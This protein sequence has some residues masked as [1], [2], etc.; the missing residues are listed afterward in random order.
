MAQFT[1]NPQQQTPIILPSADTQKLLQTENGYGNMKVVSA[2][3]VTDKSKAT[4][5]KIFM[6][7]RFDK[8][9]YTDE[10]GSEVNLDG[11]YVPCAI[12]EFIPSKVIKKTTMASQ[13]RSGTAKEHIGFG[14][15]MIDVKGML[16][17]D[18]MLYPEEDLKQLWKYWRCNKAVGI[19]HDICTILGVHEVVIEDM[20]L[21]NKQGF[22]NVQPF[23]MT[24][25]SDKPVALELNKA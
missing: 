20:K 15:V 13:K 25:S 1:F 7:L 10:N 18:G 11:L 8:V 12:L 19:L 21:T 6:P 5:H 24:L 22:Q 4:G 14:D 17:G 3:D 16:I 23:S 9:T 2:K